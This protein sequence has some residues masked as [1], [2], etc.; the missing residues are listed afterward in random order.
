MHFIRHKSKYFKLNSHGKIIILS[1]KV[2]LTYIKYLA[3]Y[4]PEECSQLIREYKEA[5]L[6]TI[7][8]EK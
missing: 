5:F 2:G 3:C 1:G 6:P 7:F 8:S 4:D